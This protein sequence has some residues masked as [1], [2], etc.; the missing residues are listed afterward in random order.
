MHTFLSICLAFVL[1]LSMPP[2]T[3][4]QHLGFR[5]LKNRTKRVT[6]PFELHSNLI[7][8]PVQVNDGEVLKFIL[9]TGV[10]TAILTNGMYVDGLPTVN[11]RIISLMGAGQNGEISAYVSSGISFSLPEGVAAQGNSM[12][13]LKEDY[14]QLDNFLGT[15]IH[16]ILG[17]EVFSRFVV[18]IDYM[19]Q[20]IVL[21][22]TE[23]FKP[24]RSY[25]EIPID[26]EDT[27][28]YINNVQLT[29]ND[30][31]TINAKLM[32]DTGASHSL[33]LNVTH[34]D[35]VAVPNP[36]IAG[37]L[38]RGLSG[39]IYGHMAR[40]PAMEM[41]KYT[42]KDVTSSFPEA[43]EFSQVLATRI[44]HQGSMGGAVLKR[45]KVIFDYAHG[46]MYLKKNRMFKKRFEYNMSGMEMLVTGPFLST[47]AVSKISPDSPADRAGLREGDIVLSVNG[48]KPPV[49]TLGM[50]NSIVNRKPGRSVTV[51][52][53]QDGKI[54]KKKFRLERVL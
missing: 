35:S 26:I 27:K 37:Y 19:R 5:I 11:D 54:V 46:K 7:V 53:F 8:I 12:L 52:V 30:S 41:D 28:P 10:R 42:L 15:R 6:I 51:R 3:Q 23:H 34:H 40:V 48:I 22:K 14:L 36:N 43:N 45:F 29:L 24:R 33:M 49:L 25:T 44:Q 9:D 16:G 50:Y 21:H 4:A 38:G 18:E 31:T 13:I 2:W 32:I 20:E 1:F 47:F 17:Y 39:D